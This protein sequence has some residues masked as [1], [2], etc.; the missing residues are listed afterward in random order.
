MNNGLFKKLYEE[1]SEIPIIDIHTHLNHLRLKANDLSDIVLYHYIATELATSGMPHE[2]L[3]IKDPSERIRKCLPF[4]K[5]IRN[6]STFWALKQILSDLFE[7]NEDLNEDSLPLLQEKFQVFEENFDGVSFLKERLKMN[8]V[9]L[10]LQFTN[11]YITF[12]PSF[13]TGSLRLEGLSKDFSQETLRKLE[14][15]TLFEIKNR[16]DFRDGLIMVF[17]L[18]Q[19]FIH[20]IAIS[21]NPSEIIVDPDERHVDEA[22]E[23]I[24]LGRQL[25]FD[26][27]IHVLSFAID[28]FL[29]LIEGNRIAF[30]LMLGVERPV[31]G[32]SPPDYAIVVN[33]LGQLL[34]LCP[35]FHKYG[36]INFD[37]ISASKVQT[38]EL[39]VISKNYNNVFVSGFWWYCYYPSIM[40]ERIE[41]RLQ[42]LPMN[43][44]C[45]FFSDAYVPEWCFG[46]A[47]LTK[48]QLSLSLSKLIEQGYFSMELAVEVARRL[49]YENALEIY[50]L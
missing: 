16:N 23:K 9:F 31:V 45:A 29:K 19:R 37:V 14:E 42:M 25:A 21:L 30:Q 12:D 17:Q 49:L 27:K 22:I 13:F 2:F 32:A 41:E 39:N 33:E 38:H 10:T 7:F 4:L 26:E 40:D 3:S 47:E 8:R 35:L 44:W 20:S 28:T 11:R 18:F 1:I 50:R 5:N 34:S 15:I 36:E 43:K 48:H 6:T 46:K 24:R